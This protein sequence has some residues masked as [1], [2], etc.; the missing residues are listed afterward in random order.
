MMKKMRM[1]INKAKATFTSSP[2]H[3][4]ATRAGHRESTKQEFGEDTKRVNGG[5]ETQ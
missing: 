2:R 5:R 3:N 1:K 4:L